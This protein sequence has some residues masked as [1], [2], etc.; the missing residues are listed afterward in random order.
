MGARA[1][2]RVTIGFSSLG[3]ARAMWP[4]RRITLVGFGGRGHA[5][6]TNWKIWEGIVSE[7]T[8]LSTILQRPDTLVSHMHAHSLEQAQKGKSVT[9]QKR[10][11]LAPKKHAHSVKQRKFCPKCRKTADC[12]AVGNGRTK[13]C[14]CSKTFKP[15]TAPARVPACPHC[16]A[17]NV[18]CNGA[19]FR[20]K[21]CDK[22]FRPR[23]GVGLKAYRTRTAAGVTRKK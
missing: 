21:P 20:C 2:H 6:D 22:G 1:A 4:T 19:T 3:I 11:P 17:F 7:H 18:V 12:L 10:Q 14:L 13:C 15:G 5:D 23:T 16:G 8:V 9:P